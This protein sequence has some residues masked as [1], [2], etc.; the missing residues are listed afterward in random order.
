MAFAAQLGAQPALAIAA[1]MGRKYP[2]GR[3]LPS[4]RRWLDGY[5][6]WRLRQA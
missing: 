2:L 5:Y 1:G 4:K 3:H 6:A